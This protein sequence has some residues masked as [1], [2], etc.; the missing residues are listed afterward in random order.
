M[1]RPISA[2]S[3][4]GWNAAAMLSRGWL[5]RLWSVSE[6]RTGRFGG[7]L[8]P[9]STYHFGINYGYIIVGGLVG[10]TLR[11][12]TGYTE[13]SDT[14]SRQSPRINSQLTRRRSV[15]PVESTGCTVLS[16]PKLTRSSTWTCFR[17]RRKRRYD[18]LWTSYTAAINA[19][20]C[21][22]SW[23]T[24]TISVRFS[25]KLDTDFRQSRMGIGPLSNVSPGK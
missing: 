5:C 19:T 20:L 2:C 6:L 4:L 18:G 7:I 25:P 23:T 24:R 3:C 16:I 12:T 1:G 13:T 21:R 15:C 14:R 10:V 17:P 11:S 8:C 22:L 9:L